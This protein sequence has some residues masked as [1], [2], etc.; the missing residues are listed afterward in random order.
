L[1]DEAALVNCESAMGL[2]AGAQMVQYHAERLGDLS[3]EEMNTTWLPGRP[4]VFL[5]MLMHSAE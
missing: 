5:R 2:A 3:D 1:I 4:Y